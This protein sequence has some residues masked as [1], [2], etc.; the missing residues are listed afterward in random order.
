MKRREAI[1]GITT[2]TGGSLFLPGVLLTGCDP[3]P[4]KYDLFH[5]GD[6]E[7]LNEIA[8][9]ILPDTPEVPGAKA[10]NVGDFIQL[11]VT[12]CYKRKDKDA[13]LKGYDE[14]KVATKT[15]YNDDGNIFFHIYCFN[16]LLLKQ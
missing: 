13:F 3:G 11:Y 6:T 9:V 8:N 5:W 15:N 7:L 10:A 4:Y 2:V 12:D 1:A 14:F 16:Y